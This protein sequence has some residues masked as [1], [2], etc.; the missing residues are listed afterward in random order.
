MKGVICKRWVGAES[1]IFSLTGERPFLFRA[2]DSCCYG[3]PYLDGCR[4]G[5]RQLKVLFAMKRET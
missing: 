4:L 2:K 5:V 3:W 1:A